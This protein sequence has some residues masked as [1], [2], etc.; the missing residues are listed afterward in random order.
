[1][2]REVSNYMLEQ[3][4]SWLVSNGS[5]ASDLEDILRGNGLA[6][7]MNTSTREGLLDKCARG[8]KLFKY[9]ISRPSCLSNIPVMQGL[10]II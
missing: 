5:P 6:V 2:P 9:D 8:S 1:M 3:T 7:H 10:L 4:S